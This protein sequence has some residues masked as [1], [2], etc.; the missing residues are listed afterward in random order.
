MN[1]KD[2]RKLNWVLVTDWS[3]LTQTYFTLFGESYVQKTDIEIFIENIF[4][5]IARKLN[6]SYNDINRIQ[7]EENSAFYKTM[8]SLFQDLFSY[9]NKYDPSLLALEKMLRVPDVDSIKNNDVEKILHE[10]SLLKD[11]E[12][13]EVLKRLELISVKIKFNNN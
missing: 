1:A 7:K 2:I 13:I 12:K 10:F 11:T 9:F 6:L 5:D 8:K 4:K 3:E